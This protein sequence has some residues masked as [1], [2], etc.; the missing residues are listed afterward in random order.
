MIFWKL[1]KEL[2]ASGLGSYF[3]AGIERFEVVVEGSGS[4]IERISISQTLLMLSKAVFTW[5]G[6]SKASRLHQLR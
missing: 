6:R 1:C 2:C 5:D 4:M 3:E